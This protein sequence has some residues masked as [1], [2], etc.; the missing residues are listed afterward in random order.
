M[1]E[2]L[3]Y[4]REL[5]GSALHAPGHY[6]DVITLA[7]ALTHKIDDVYSAPRILALGPQGS[8]KSQV[9]TVANQLAAHA[10]PV[11]GI[12]AMTGPSYVGAFRM[13]PRHT[14]FLDEVNHLFSEAGNGGKTSA[15]YTYINQGYRRDTGY[16]QYQENRAPVLIPIFGVAFLAGL[17]LAA[18]PD[19]R[20]R[21]VLIPMKRAGSANDVADFS[22]AQVRAA[23]AYGKLC[24]DSWAKSVPALSTAGLRDL[25]PKLRHRLMDVWGPLLAVA[26][27][28]GDRWLK[29]GLLA[30]E[31]IALEGGIPVHPPEQQVILDYL[32]YVESRPVAEGVA[33]GAFAQWATT[34]EHGAYLSMKPGQFRQF[35]VSRLGPTSPFH[36]AAEGQTVRGWSGLPHQMNI[37]NAEQLRAEIAASADPGPHEEESWEDF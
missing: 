24:L 10:G 28:G 14:P 35:A 25:H 37:N 2:A 11:M 17:G 33:S 16:A 23:F 26:R 29:K 20:E 19:M 30:F 1:D 18:P 22:D 31:Y 7:C 27:A 36:M 32:D 3:D 4:A 6:L 5:T 8:G 15:F 13:N 9:L 12:R 34:R 21:S